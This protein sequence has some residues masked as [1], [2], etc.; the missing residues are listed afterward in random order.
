MIASV[1]E[2]TTMDVYNTV[3]ALVDAGVPEYLMAKVN[4]ADAKA[5][6]EAL[7]EFVAVVK[8]NPI[9]PSTP[10]SQISSSDAADISASASQLAS[11]AY[12]FMKGVDW[13]DDLYKTPIPGKSA[14]QVMKAVDKM[15][16][17]G[18]Q[19]D[20]AALQE[21][22][23]AHVKAIQGMDSK[24]VLTQ[25]DLEAILA[26]L[27]KTISSVPEATV[28]GV[29]REMSNLIGASEIPKYVF[30][31]QNP[32]EAMAAYSALVQFTQ[33]VRAAQSKGTADMEGLSSD[34]RLALIFIGVSALG[35][36]PFLH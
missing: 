21:A 13:T 5:A 20:W 22:A 16:V 4:E 17:M 30:A 27:G 28:M 26:G 36:L 7:L 11:A 19:M 23:K 33:T 1:P 3:E 2:A 9:T 18:S 34:Q 25:G 8:A 6:Y 24:G 29:Y 35:V 32:E 31:K 12:P 10:V 15:I 14:Q